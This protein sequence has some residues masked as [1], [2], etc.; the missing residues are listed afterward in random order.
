MV[1]RIR[2]PTARRTRLPLWLGALFC[3]TLVLDAT[4]L[5]AEGLSDYIA[6]GDRA[7]HR[8][9][10][11]AAKEQFCEGA[12]RFPDQPIPRLAK[13]HT[14]FALRDYRAAARALQA[15]IHLQPA[16][17]LSG[18]NLRF[19]FRDPGEFDANLDDL[20]AELTAEPEDPD[21]LFLSAYALHFSG[22]PDE[23]QRLFRHLLTLAPGHEAAATFV[24]SSPI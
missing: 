18:I 19:F 1:L 12:R 5:R 6:R 23:A 2:K 3:L 20:A 7:F 9:A 15:G 16:W 21:L 14:L 22:R 10:Y 13:G 17:S 8:G 11:E 4:A 24:P